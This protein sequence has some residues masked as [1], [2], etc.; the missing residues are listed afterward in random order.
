MEALEASAARAAADPGVELRP[1]APLLGVGRREA[2]G[3]LRVGPRRLAP[4]FDAA[5][6]LES[7]HRCDEMGTGEPELSGERLPGLVVGRLLRYRG[8]AEGA[9]PHHVAKRPR[10]ASKLACDNVP[11]IHF[12]ERN[13]ACAPTWQSL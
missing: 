7:R 3:E 5:G 1:E 4:S 13:R 12:R 6:G 8:P 10:R 9:A 2:A 11:V